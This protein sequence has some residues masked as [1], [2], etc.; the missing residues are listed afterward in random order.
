MVVVEFY[1]EFYLE[2]FLLKKKKEI[3]DGIHGNKM[4]KKYLLTKDNQQGIEY[5]KCHWNKYVIWCDFNLISFNERKG[6]TLT[7]YYAFD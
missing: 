4:T 2:L 5:P 7:K 3:K 1:L 6:K